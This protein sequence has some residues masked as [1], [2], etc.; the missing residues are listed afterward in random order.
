[1]NRRQKYHRSENAGYANT[2]NNTLHFFS[3]EGKRVSCFKDKG[4]Q[5]LIKKQSQQTFG[6]GDRLWIDFL[7]LWKTFWE[8]IYRKF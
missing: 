4:Y 8:R 6:I 1:M 5:Q 3:F 7:S 2:C